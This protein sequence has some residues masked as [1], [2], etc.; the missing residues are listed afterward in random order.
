LEA[1]LKEEQHSMEEALRR[2][3]IRPDDAIAAVADT[4]RRARA[5]WRDPYR[6]LAGVLFLGPTGEETT[7]LAGDLAQLLFDDGNAVTRIDMS[8]YKEQRSL[9]WLVGPPPGYPGG[10][11]GG[12]LTEAVRRRPDQV[13]LFDQIEQAHPVVLNALRR[14]LEEGRLPGSPDRMVDVR[15]TLLIM[16]S[17][18]G[19]EP[20]RGWLAAGRP[21]EEIQARTVDL[22]RD[23]FGADFVDRIDYVVV[24]PVPAPGHSNEKV[25]TGGAERVGGPYA[26]GTPVLGRDGHIGELVGVWEEE[27][28]GQPGWLLVREPHLL[29]LGGTVRIVPASWVARATAERIVLD[30]DLETVRRCPP[31]RK[32]EELR[33]D[34]AEAISQVEIL[35]PFRLAIHVDVHR[36]LVELTG[37]V[38]TEVQR[39]AAEDAARSVAGV[40]AVRD[41]LVDDETLQLEVAQALA[42][43][44][45]VRQA[46]LKVYCALGEVTLVG[47]LPSAAALRTAI[48]LAGAVPGVR[49]LRLDLDV[50]PDRSP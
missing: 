39:R 24:F 25:A 13:I 34:V 3:V 29:L 1:K 45:V 15:A 22:L 21:G 7:R 37:H 8:R 49:E 6:P 30:A 4:V 44:P 14:I 46:Q 32:D 26:P 9:L 23:A 17:R 27:A 48:E 50:A 28:T 20:L 41:R 35:R 42:E 2:R 11:E 12:E 47:Q 40:R 16:T 5:G 10:A 43:D 38:R 33:S 19:A 31:L 18:V 36:G